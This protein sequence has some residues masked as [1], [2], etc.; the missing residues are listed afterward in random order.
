LGRLVAGE[1]RFTGE[2][3]FGAAASGFAVGDRA[4]R[5]GT[6]PNVCKF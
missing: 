6:A 3:V 1:D 2:G 5:P 4:K